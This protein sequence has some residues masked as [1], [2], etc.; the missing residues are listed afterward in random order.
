MRA[1]R[2][3]GRGAAA[4]ACWLITC[5]WIQAPPPCLNSGVPWGAR[6][7]SRAASP[8][9]GLCRLRG[10]AAPPCAAAPP[11]AD[12]V[13]GAP[14]AGTAA[15]AAGS[16]PSPR[17]GLPPGQ[18]QHAGAPADELGRRLQQ[19]LAQQMRHSAH[20]V[21]LH[22]QEE[23]A[24]RA[25]FACPPGYGEW[26]GGG[27][28]EPAAVGGWSDA[29]DPFGGLQARPARP[30]LLRAQI[31]RERLRTLPDELPQSDGLQQVRTMLQHEAEAAGDAYCGQD[32]PS[33]QPPR[34]LWGGT[35]AEAALP[36]PAS[37]SAFPWGR[38]VPVRAEPA[39][40]STPP[41][42]LNA[43][44]GAGQARMHDAQAAYAALHSQSDSDEDAPTWGG[45]ARQP[46][47][48][49]YQRQD[50]PLPAPSVRFAPPGWSGKAVHGIA[51]FDDDDDDDQLDG[52]PGGWNQNRHPAADFRPVLSQGRD[53]FFDA[54][55]PGPSASGWPSGGWGNAGPRDSPHRWFGTRVGRERQRM[56]M[57]PEEM[58]MWA[59]EGSPS[60]SRYAA[61]S[62]SRAGASSSWGT[63]KGYD[64][65]RRVG[66]KRGPYKKSSHGSAYSVSS[67]ARRDSLP[68]TRMHEYPEAPSTA[69]ARKYETDL[70]SNVQS[71][72]AQ[73]WFQGLENAME[74]QRGSS[75]KRAH[76]WLDA[77]KDVVD[78]QVTAQSMQSRARNLRKQDCRLL[79][80]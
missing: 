69:R 2:R 14:A 39:R 47:H 23:Y 1:R 20:E 77:L 30:G 66:R 34:S 11:A 60:H 21:A 50:S 26:A 70:V 55:G 54:R 68:W 61:S 24:Q 32:N 80:A 18:Q 43:G 64:S 67:T 29:D 8:R 5:L 49:P 6:A 48:N 31:A 53:G 46:A 4:A 65:S 56:Q 79:D 40:P 52:S 36:S 28:A 58:S 38:S 7:P 33:M 12:I 27:S 51:D 72:E 25:V 75:S 3:A 17:A 62:R 22:E 9:C 37:Y 63:G 15:P 74:E 42:A 57:S 41:D 45:S 13:A 71:R 73:R 10:G 76:S 35:N 59:D 44:R 19:V 16:A 78:A